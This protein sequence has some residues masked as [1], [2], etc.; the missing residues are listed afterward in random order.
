MLWGHI[1]GLAAMAWGAGGVALMIAFKSSLHVSLDMNLIDLKPGQ[2]FSGIVKIV[3]KRS[4]GPVVLRV[5]DG[6]FTM[7]AVGKASDFEVGDMAELVGPAMR[8]LGKI[9]IEIKTIHKTE[10]TLPVIDDPLTRDADLM[11]RTPFNEGPLKPLLIAAANRIRQ[12]IVSDQPVIL[13]H[14]ADADGSTGSILLEKALQDLCRSRGMKPEQY[15]YR[16]PSKVPFYDVSDALWDAS[17]TKRVIESRGLPP[18]L[19]VVIDNGS[20]EEDLFALKLMNAMG[21]SLMVIDHHNPGPIIDGRVA[22][23][24]FLEVHVNP[25]LVGGSYWSSSGMLCYE[26]AHILNPRV[27]LPLLPAISAV[28]D[29]SQ[30]E[31]GMAYIAGAGRSLEELKD[32]ALCFDFLPYHLRTEAGTSLYDAVLA[33][34]DLAQTICEEI[35][36]HVERQLETI[37]PQ[38][39]VHDCNGSFLAVVDL[40]KAGDRFSFPPPGKFTG[41]IHDKIK[42]SRKGAVMTVATVAGLIIIRESEPILPVRIVIEEFKSA[43][44]KIPISGGGHDVAGTIKCPQDEVGK[45]V[46][47]IL[48]RLKRVKK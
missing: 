25:L 3:G 14:H 40:S 45:M 5:T 17:F 21:F 39:V 43:N 1:F 22:V 26:I 23:D 24:P 38:V 44:P 42:E 33:D 15:V 27:N 2:L 9:Q 30:S 34:K 4:P 13:R 48:D 35:R 11:V 36:A 16:M 47:F 7:D 6:S 18:P 37:L 31:E 10:K 41:L 20:T 8:R 12:A 19:I 28:A 32:L 46:E 29:R